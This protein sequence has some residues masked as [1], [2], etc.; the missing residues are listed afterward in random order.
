[1]QGKY[2]LI[3]NSAASL[4]AADWIR[5]IDALGSILLLNR[6]KGEAYSR[7]ALPY[8]VSGERSLESILIRRKPDYQRL[9]ITLIEEAEASGVD[10]SAHQVILKDGR[11]ISYG[12]LLI[13]TG[14]EVMVPPVRGLAGVP[15]HTLWTLADAVA[16]KNAAQAAKRAL[17]IGGGFIG[18]LVAEALRKLAMKLTIV[19]MANQL[20]PQLLDSEGGKIFAEAVAAS[21]VDLRLGNQ[22]ES[23]ARKGK[24]ILVRLQGGAEIETDL[25]VAAA[26]VKPCLGCI[27]NGVI[28]T[29]KGVVVDSHLRTS[30]PDV[31]AAGDVAEVP[32]FITGEQVLHAIWPTAVD[33]GRIAGG[34]MAGRMIPYAGSLGMNVVSLFGLTLAEV[35]RFRESA[36]DS[37][38]SQGSG[39]GGRYRKVVVDSGGK[40]AGA[41]YLGDENGVSE[42]GIL[43]HAIRRRESWRSFVAQRSSASYAAMFA[44]ITPALSRTHV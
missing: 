37:V 26:G 1:M 23:V 7:V 10:P 17:V 44:R 39:K 33:E 43:H 34:N 3:G 25:L 19:E 42:M 16:L 28:L 41:M 18:M 20:M 24:A 35:G 32:D 5:K 6:E 31:Y 9:G 15:H 8:F 22:V 12:K 4:A 11:K 36:G 13:G 2:V 40:I 27:A 29:K 38:E 14:S 30:V 21:G